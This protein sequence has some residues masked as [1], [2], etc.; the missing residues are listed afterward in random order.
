MLVMLQILYGAF[1]AGLKAGLLCPV[2]PAMCNVGNLLAGNW[3]GNFDLGMPEYLVKLNL[4]KY[5]STSCLFSLWCNCDSGYKIK[6][7]EVVGYG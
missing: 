2:F 1:V 3:I 5:T 4:A 7:M 6:K